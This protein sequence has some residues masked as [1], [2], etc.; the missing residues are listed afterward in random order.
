MPQ[1]WLWKHSLQGF[2]TE[3]KK[4]WFCVIK[5][6]TFPPKSCKGDI[7]LWLPS[8]P[9]D[10]NLP[11]CK[12]T[13]WLLERLVLS[14]AVLWMGSQ[15]SALCV[16]WF[17]ATHYQKLVTSH[18]LRDFVQCVYR[19]PYGGIWSAVKSKKRKAMEIFFGTM[20]ALCESNRHKYFMKSGLL[21]WKDSLELLY[22]VK[23][24]EAF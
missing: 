15:P 24:V 19:R 23:L 8:S 10:C 4:K 3:G 17:H 12:S 16:W 5:P 13:F 9:V 21:S 14:H 11:H 1:Q 6:L 22:P 2:F 18:I 20:L 7:L